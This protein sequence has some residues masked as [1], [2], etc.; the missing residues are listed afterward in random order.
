ML[1]VF[2]II[3]NAPPAYFACEGK[4][5]G[6]ACTPYSFYGCSCSSGV[7]VLMEDCADNP[8]TKINECLVCNPE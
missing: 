6:D 3:Y 5:P 2:F 1:S 8:D 4:K 7:C